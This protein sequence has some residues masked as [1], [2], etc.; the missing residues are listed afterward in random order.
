[1]TPP[2]AAFSRTPMKPSPTTAPATSAELLRHI[3]W[4]LQSNRGRTL[5]TASDF[6]RWWA[7]CQSVRDFA[8]G[9]MIATERACVEQD[10]KRVYY[11]SME[12]L[13]GRLLT[14]NL[15][16]LGLEEAARELLPRLGPEAEA[17][18]ATTPDAAWGMAV[19]AAWPPVSSIPWPRWNTRAMAT[20]CA[21][22]MG[23][24]GRSSPAAGKGSGR[25]I[26]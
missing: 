18:F 8:L 17:F 15:I 14:N 5:A 4:H 26:G 6:D 9:R 21:T 7:V 22:S 11:L 13:M 2:L 3:E 12:F 23:C 19:W 1:M 24:S 10:A 20:G 25:M 16:A